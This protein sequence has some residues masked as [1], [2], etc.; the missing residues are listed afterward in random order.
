MSSI[1][2]KKGQQQ[3]F[4][5]EGL[6]I[7]LFLRQVPAT[8]VHALQLSTWKVAIYKQR[9]ELGSFFTFSTRQFLKTR[10]MKGVNAESE[11]RWNIALS[12]QCRKMVFCQTNKQ[13]GKK[14]ASLIIPT[15][16]RNIS[17]NTYWPYPERKVSEGAPE[18]FYFSLA[19]VGKL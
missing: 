11:A 14:K 16:L 9:D 5:K 10:L 3:E 4:V 18:V 8:Q 19:C 15:F 7:N 6:V 12:D 17:K 2:S 13:R 1:N